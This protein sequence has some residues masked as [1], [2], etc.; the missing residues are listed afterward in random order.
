VRIWGRGVDLERF[1]PAHRKP[2][3]REAVGSPEAL[4]LLYV[5]RLTPEKDL[6]V[7]FEAYRRAASRSPRPI[8]LVLTGDGAYAPRARASAPEGVT[9][10]GHLE[11]DR[12]AAAYASADVF[13]FPSRTETLG[14]VVLEALA[15]GLPVVAAAEGGVL[16]NVRDGETGLLCTPGDP[17]S[18]AQQILKLVDQPSLRERLS[19]NARAWAERRTWERA[20]SPLVDGY[21]EAVGR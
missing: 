1:N 4:H 8:Q 2:D 20:F 19:R 16:E 6:S 12:L 21:R 18:F 5:G 3:V 7:L 15:S 14:N 11:G 17:G 10:T 9:F 13:V